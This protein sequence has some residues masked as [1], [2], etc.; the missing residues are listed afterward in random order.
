L[1]L[2]AVWLGSGLLKA[3]VFGVRVE[4][5]VVLGGAGVALL[6]I[7]LLATLPPALRAMRVDIRRGLAG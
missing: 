2:V 1:G 5:P 7:A 6:G 4:S 3:F